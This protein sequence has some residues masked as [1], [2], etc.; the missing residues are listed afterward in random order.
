MLSDAL[1]GSTGKAFPVLLN[2]RFK[3]FTGLHL[4]TVL[5]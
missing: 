1:T 2:D 3:S 4:M 5:W